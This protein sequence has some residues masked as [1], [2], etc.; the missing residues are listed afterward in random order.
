MRGPFANLRT[1]C[2]TLRAASERCLSDAPDPNGIGFVALKETPA[3]YR[4]VR[5]F[6]AGEPA[7]YSYYRGFVEGHLFIISKMRLQRPGRADGRR[8]C[9]RRVHRVPF[10]RAPRRGLDR[11]GG[12]RPAG[13]G[14][15]R[16]CPRPQRAARSRQAPDR[17][18]LCGSA[19]AASGG[20]MNARAI[21]AGGDANREGGRAESRSSGV[22]HPLCD[23]ARDVRHND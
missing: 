13:G 9:G 3:P 16:L 11:S 10:P 4:A 7:W 19:R 8:W 12:Q 1:F 5:V 20:R 2:K 22:A 14:R 17:V 23:S 6:G 21:P 15:V 18:P